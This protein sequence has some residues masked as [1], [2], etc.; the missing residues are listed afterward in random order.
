MAIQLWREKSLVAKAKNRRRFIFFFVLY[1]VII[2]SLGF[3][4]RGILNAYRK[5]AE[6]YTDM[7]NHC[8]TQT[9]SPE[10]SFMPNYDFKIVCKK[11]IN[12]K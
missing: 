6:Y 5:V 7:G 2:I 1:L 10:N 9:T 4:P 11:D 8:E 3:V 12:N